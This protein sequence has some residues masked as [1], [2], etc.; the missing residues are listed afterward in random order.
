MCIQKCNFKFHVVDCYLFHNIL[1]FLLFTC[2]NSLYVGVDNRM[3]KNKLYKKSVHFHLLSIILI[4]SI[5]NIQARK[6]IIV[7]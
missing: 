7:H 3:E 5:S 2:V 6:S 4:C 1:L